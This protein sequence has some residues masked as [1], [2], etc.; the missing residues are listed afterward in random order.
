MVIHERDQ[1]L[2]LASRHQR[3]KGFITDHERETTQQRLERSAAPKL[4]CGVVGVGDPEKRGSRNRLRK[5]RRP[6]AH[7]LQ[8]QRPSLHSAGPAGQGTGVVSKTRL[9]QQ[10]KPLRSCVARCPG[11]QFGSTVTRKHSPRSQPMQGRQTLTECGV[12]SIRVRAQLFREST[13]PSLPR[14]SKRHQG[15]TGIKDLAG[16]TTQ[17]IGCRRQIA[18]VGLRQEGSSMNPSSLRHRA[19]PRL[20]FPRSRDQRTDIPCC[21][22]ARRAT[23]NTPPQDAARTI[24][25]GGGAQAASGLQHSNW[26]P[27][28]RSDRHLS[29]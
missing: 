12:A 5:W 19:E 16:P 1:R 4:A 21:T 17:P 25:C 24:H 28:E 27:E 22:R 9:R 29:R 6:R 23:P 7:P 15:G 13:E 20:P 11:K 18:A 3:Q 2:V 26:A 14:Q 8:G 10:R